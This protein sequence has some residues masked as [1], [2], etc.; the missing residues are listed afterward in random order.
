MTDHQNGA[1]RM[2]VMD[3]RLAGTVERYHTWPTIRRQTVAEHTW[4]LLRVYTAIFGPPDPET[5]LYIMFHDGA[6]IVTGD[7][8]YPVK[9]NNPDLRRQF[10]DVEDRAKTSQGAFWGFDIPLE[11][12]MAKHAKVAELIEM[13]EEGMVETTLGSRFGWTVAVRTL[14]AAHAM[15]GAF[16]PEDRRAITTYVLRRLN[17]FMQQQFPDET[18]KNLLAVWREPVERP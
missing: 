6:E 15:L 9:R 7:P 16:I 14:D 1:A 2:I 11:C 10:K 3:L 18:A 8:P 4:Q 12:K 5:F 17:L 13:A